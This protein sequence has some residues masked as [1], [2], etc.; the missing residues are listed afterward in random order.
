MADEDGNALSLSRDILD[1][2]EDSLLASGSRMDVGDW[3][4]HL[5]SK[6]MFAKEC[7]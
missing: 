3:Q 1:I 7:W 5:K 2:C 4:L 6:V